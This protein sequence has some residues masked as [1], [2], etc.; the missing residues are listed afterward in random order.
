M[1]EQTAS[2]DAD[3][4]AGGSEAPE[5]LTLRLKVSA[6]PSAEA[7][8]AR[9]TAPLLRQP[10]VLRDFPGGDHWL[11]GW[12]VADK[13]EGRPFVAHV[14]DVTTG[15][16]TEV[17]GLLDDPEA[18]DLYFAGGQRPPSEDEWRWAV[19][20]LREAAADAA[21]ID[22]DE[23]GDGSDGPAEDEVAP[24]DPAG[25]P[26]AEV[27]PAEAAAPAGAAAAPDG[28]LSEAAASAPPPPVPP[29]PPATPPPGP[30]GVDVTVAKFTEH[31]PDEEEE[32][33][34]DLPEL[35]VY[36][37]FPPLANTQGHDG[38]VRRVI[39]V[40][41]RDPDGTHRV[42]GVRV[43]DGEIL[44]DPE[45]AF[46]ATGPEVGASP[47]GVECGPVAG[48]DQARVRVLKGDTVL[49]DLLVVRP[50][51]SSGLN[52][53]G[54]ELRSVDHRG[55]R[56][57]DR[58]HLPIL[59]VVYADGSGESR[60]FRGWLYE[61]SAFEAEGE[62]IASGVR[63]CSEPAR[64]ILDTGT[65]GGTFRGVALWLEGDDLV[66]TSQIA[67][68]WHRY[69]TEW[70]LRADGTILPRLGVAVARHAASGW[71]HT[72]HAYW[73]FDFDIV[74]PDENTV[75]E[76]NEPQVFGTT[77][78]HTLRYE[79]RRDQDPAHNRYW[80][81]RHNRASRTYSVVPGPTDQD[82][83]EDAPTG[84]WLLRYSPDEIDD[85]Q[86]L[87]DDPHR[88]R[89]AL[90]GFISGEPTHRSD[91]VLWYAAHL[92]HDPSSG[93]VGGRVGPDLRARL[94]GGEEP[95]SPAGPAPSGPPIVRPQTS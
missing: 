86:G 61:E 2:T 57:L 1:S 65:D 33:R 45:G 19:T 11:L 55:K 3:A 53:S 49:W 8:V 95:E 41:V 24:A 88:S 76:H 50:S 32:P 74:G 44:D 80:R 12:D 40:G 15:R 39:T 73:R 35:D 54:V 42:V 87:T 34:R 91:V 56:A 14:S 4:A 28:G 18:T 84:L 75:Q 64:T 37:P 22:G 29:L 46:P 25:P 81:V 68:G 27:A 66:V 13:V 69:V 21:G 7:E 20:K 47:A 71:T 6:E 36:R 38:V 92:R 26:E 51:S 30:A 82:A 67:A 78:W 43:G 79:M 17:R 31:I 77:S 5:D 85:A 48:S 52:G 72:H 10:W 59:E 23:G 90:D 63:L 9:A 16:M 83:A 89:A 60:H 93:A 94:W 62:D 70:R 58:A